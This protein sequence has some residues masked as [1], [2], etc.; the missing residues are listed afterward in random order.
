[1][2]I[3]KEVKLKVPSAVPLKEF[4]LKEGGI[5][6]GAEVQEDHYLDFDDLRIKKAGSAL[7]IRK[8]GE[9]AKLTYK[10][11]L[12]ENKIKAREEIEAEV[13][14]IDAL[15]KILERIGL[16]VK[17]IVKKVRETIFYK[18]L[19]FE[20]DSVERL[21]DFLEVE[22]KDEEQLKIVKET[23][24]R[25]GIKWDPIIKSYAEMLEELL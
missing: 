14:D 23:V 11:P 6:V 18:G 15:I 5:Y 24:E 7:R 19:N 1:M 12:L 3:E 21:G 17:I 22:V 9:K 10:G 2:A 25:I 13:Q 20:I 16:K 4:L 8:S